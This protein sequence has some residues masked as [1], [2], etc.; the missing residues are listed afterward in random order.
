MKLLKPDSTIK[1]NKN[2]TQITFPKLYDACNYIQ[3]TI[4]LSKHNNSNY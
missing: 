3:Y 1:Y 4:K 2:T